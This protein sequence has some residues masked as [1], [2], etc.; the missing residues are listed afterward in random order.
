MRKEGEPAIEKVIQESDVIDN[1]RKG[2]AGSDEQNP[3]EKINSLDKMEL[4]EKIKTPEGLLDYMKNNL[5][6]GWVGKD[7]RKLYSPKYEGWGV[8]EPPN[9]YYLQSPEELLD[10]KHG[11]CWDQTELERSWFSKNNYEFKTFIAMVGRKISQKNPAHTFLAYKKN[12]KWIWFENTMEQSNGVHEFE[13]LHDLE[14]NVKNII[15]NNAV[16][17]GATDEDLK[18]FLF[19]EYE[20][21]VYGCSQDEFVDN[22][23]NKHPP[24]D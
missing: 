24:A 16:N 7:N 1:S 17:N 18:Q 9:N 4:F 11:L 14:E 19:R 20:K 8:G 3:E 5:T 22:I 12:D 2:A 13:N 21:P 15:S 6:Y 10:T 23:V